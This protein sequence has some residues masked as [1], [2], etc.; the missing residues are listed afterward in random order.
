MLAMAELP[1]PCK[2]GR[3]FDPV[4]IGGGLRRYATPNCA[5]KL[6]MRRKRARDKKK[7]RKNQRALQFQPSARSAANAK[8]TRPEEKTLFA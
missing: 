8:S 5:T 3:T 6:R 7:N 2:C 4:V 1:C